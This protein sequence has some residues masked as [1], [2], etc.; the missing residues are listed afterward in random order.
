MTEQFE[1]IGPKYR[2]IAD[3]LR[4]DIESGKYP[5]GKQLPT[6]SELMQ[7]YGVAVNTVER[8]I[9]ELRD[10]GMVETAQGAGMFVRE[11][12]RIPSGGS[13]SD[14]LD[15]LEAEMA[16]MRKQLANYQAALMELYHITGQNYPYGESSADSVRKVG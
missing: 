5:P 14:R 12:P 2:R 7:R 6:K 4:A 3:D 1:G 11:Q 16:D 13:A 9:K 8:A 15:A 10:A